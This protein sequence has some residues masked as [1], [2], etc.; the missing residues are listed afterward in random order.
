MDDQNPGKDQYRPEVE[1]I[2]Q[3]FSRQLEMIRAV[4]EID[5]SLLGASE[6]S[7]PAILAGKFFHPE[8][9]DFRNRPSVDE[10]AEDL[11]SQLEDYAKS[12][13]SM[14]RKH[15]DFV[16]IRE[17]FR[18]TAQL[19]RVV[20]EHS[21][22]GSR[23]VRNDLIFF[24]GASLF[25]D[26]TRLLF[27]SVRDRW[28]MFKTGILR[29][30]HSALREN[31]KALSERT[32]AKSTEK[33]RENLRKLIRKVRANEKE[34]EVRSSKRFLPMILKRGLIHA[35]VVT[36]GHLIAYEGFLKKRRDWQAQIDSVKKRI[37][38]FLNSHISQWEIEMG[39][40]D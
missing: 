40:S 18:R 29:K 17:A 25:T 27:F 26:I 33:C 15:D 19:S 37:L 34:R 12:P 16:R 9:K 10:M 39:Q 2:K 7:A 4:G 1:T 5:Y 38:P 28:R 3:E 36:T 13:I 35:G 31:K 11:I 23:F 14:E 20:S 8:L 21:A 24:T 32:L 22:S 6:Q 30:K